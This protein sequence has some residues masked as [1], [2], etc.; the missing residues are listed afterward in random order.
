MVT[1]K[2][3]ESTHKRTDVMMV[4]EHTVSGS[5]NQGVF[6]IK[7]YQKHSNKRRTVY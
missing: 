6:I 7:L 5:Q 4:T 1:V 3:E 2:A